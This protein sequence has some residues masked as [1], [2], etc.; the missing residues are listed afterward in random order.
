MLYSG[1]TI[2][3]IFLPS[4]GGLLMDKI[5][6]RNGLLLFSFVLALGQGIFTLGG[7]DI[8]F[9]LM[10]WGRVIFGAG[11]ELMYVGRSA[12]ISNWFIHFELQL[13]MSI[14]SSVPN[15]G[16]L[17]NGAAVSYIYNINKSFFEAFGVGFLACCASFMIAIMMAILDKK[18]EKHDDLKLE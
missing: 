7:K 14:I 3:G 18:M 4:F 17:F 2:P 9:M 13:A 10:F 6:Q 15:S 8:N 1:Y 12:M 16:Y 5:G 11:C